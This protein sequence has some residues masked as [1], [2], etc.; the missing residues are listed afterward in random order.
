MLQRDYISRLIREFMAALQRYLEKQEI[1]ERRKAV[2]D[3]YR[4]YLGPYD[5][6]HTSDLDE[7]M[8]S[9]E[10]FPEE[11]RLDRME[12]L[13]ELYY[14][15][16]DMLSEPR[17]TMQLDMAFSLFSFVDRHGRTFSVERINK[18]KDIGRRIK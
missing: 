11:E 6:Y 2:E 16:A 10:N 7:I 18:M 3:L 14:A 12:M 8:A 1:T 9:F 5:F 15:E 17:R 4:Q 13:A